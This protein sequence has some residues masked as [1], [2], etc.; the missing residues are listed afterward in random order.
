ML[1]H[2]GAEV[3]VPVFDAKSMILD[4]LTNPWFM[5]KGNLA[6]GYNVVTGN[7]DETDPRNK[8][9]G[10]VHTG[11]QWLP[12]RDRFCT[13]H[14][15]MDNEMPIGL[16]IFGD[17]S[18]IDLHG[19]LSLTPIIFT[20]TLFKRSARNNINFWRPL[21]YIP[22][23]GYGKNKADK[24]DMR[25]KIQDKHICLSIALESIKEIH[26]M[27]GFYAKAM[28]REVL[29][30]VWIHYFIGDTEG[31][32]KWL[33][34]LPGNKKQISHPYRDCA[35][36]YS[37]L[38]N[39]NPICVYTTLE[40]MRASKR[41]KRDNVNEGRLLLKL[42]SR[43]DIKNALLR[44]Y[45]SLSDNERGP[46]GMMPPESLHTSGSGL[47]KYMFE[48]VRNQIGAG[49]DRDDIDKQ[50]VRICM[51]IKR[52]SKHDFPRD[53]MRN[54]LIDGMKCQAEER[55]G[56]LFLLLCV[57]HTNNGSNKLQKAL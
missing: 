29:V 26:R 7:V 53:A 40:D 33:G 27:G 55:K 56:N 4:L 1:L 23:L 34:H 3:T 32:N 10:K 18:H 46:Y 36:D 30:K 49:K 42:M 54:G 24:T 38:S 19:A 57:A 45:H 13:S 35:C 43:Y 31:N 15:P 2:N 12:T 8:C 14:D 37:E 16:I 44:R 52:Q 25:D 51:A 47:I 22:N 50:H 17:K 6:A 39:P 11:D 20:L 5:N 48:S 9:Y 41:V 21:A 28:G